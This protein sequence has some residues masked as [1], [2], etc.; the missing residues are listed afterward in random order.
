MSDQPRKRGRPKGSRNKSKLKAGEPSTGLAGPSNETKEPSTQ[1]L[2]VSNETAPPAPLNVGEGMVQR[3]QRLRQIQT[4]KKGV[5][6]SAADL[7]QMKFKERE[8]VTPGLVRRGGL[9][10]CYGIMKTGKSALWTQYAIAAAIGRKFFDLPT[11]K[12]TVLYVT[13]EGPDDDA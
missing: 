5:W 6:I 8:W 12:S 11:T 13:L 10:L 1:G 3:K 4:V 9:G 2:Q 7:G